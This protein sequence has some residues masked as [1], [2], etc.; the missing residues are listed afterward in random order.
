MSTGPLSP[1]R[2]APAPHQND[3]V[4]TCLDL[5]HPCGSKTHLPED[6]FHNTD[7]KQNLYNS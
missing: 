7:S 5:D 2:L 4:Y 6:H 3:R 1:Y